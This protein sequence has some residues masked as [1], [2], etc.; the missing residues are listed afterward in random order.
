MIVDLTQSHKIT[1]KTV[2]VISDIHGH[3]DKLN[4]VIEQVAF[5]GAQ[6]VFVGDYIDRGPKGIEVLKMVREMEYNPKDWGFSKVTPLMGNHELMAARAANNGDPGDMKLW[7]HNGGRFEEYNAIK[8]DFRLWMTTLPLFYSH[9]RKIHYRG[10]EKNLLV[11]H[12]SVDPSE[13]LSQQDSDTLLWGRTV[14]GWDFETLV[15]NGHTPCEDGKPEVYNTSSGPVI[16]IDTGA[17]Y[18]GDV[19]GL[20]LEEV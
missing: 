12:G 1:E 7:L 18:D 5:H 20:L 19:C 16:R 13:S 2:V 17:A 6:V 4:D 15:V 14:R 10:E 9:P 8:N 3:L 11:T